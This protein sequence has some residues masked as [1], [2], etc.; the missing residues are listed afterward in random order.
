MHNIHSTLQFT[1]MTETAKWVITTTT[2]MMTAM[3]K[4]NYN[5]D[6]ADD[7]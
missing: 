2:A 3:Y 7:N 6:D 5:N 1:I 4:Y